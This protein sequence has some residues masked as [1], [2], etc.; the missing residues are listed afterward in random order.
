[1]SKDK[2]ATLQSIEAALHYSQRRLGM[3][4]CRRAR[5]LTKEAQAAVARA[6]RRASSAK[7]LSS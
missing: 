5:R 2:V 7:A 1:M 6:I 4:G 3:I